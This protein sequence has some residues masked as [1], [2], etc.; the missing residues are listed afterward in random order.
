MPRCRQRE[1]AYPT[2]RIKITERLLQQA[3]PHEPIWQKQRPNMQNQK[4]KIWE[5][6]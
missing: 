6:M 1:V 5:L 2:N 3:A 4:A